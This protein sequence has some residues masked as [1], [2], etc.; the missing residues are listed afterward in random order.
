MFVFAH[1]LLQRIQWERT[2]FFYSDDGKV[3]LPGLQRFSLLHQGIEM[4]ATAEHQTLNPVGQKRDNWVGEKYLKIRIVG[5]TLV[6]Q[7]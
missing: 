1:L 7:C 4:F 5:I 3:M 6:V 2:E